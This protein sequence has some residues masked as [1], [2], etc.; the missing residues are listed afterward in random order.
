MY[1]D[2][3]IAAVLPALNEEQALPRVIAGLQ[4]L[5]GPDGQSVIDQIMVCDNGSSDAT[6][7]VA[8]A[9][10]AD[11]VYQAQ[12]GYGI[13]C[14]TAIAELDP[15][16]IILFVDADDSCYVEQAMPLIQAIAEGD[17]LAIGSRTMGTIESG[18]LTYPQRAGN[19]LASL[20]IR[21]LWGKKV[22]DLGPFRAIC[23]S[24]YKQL[25]MQDERFGWTVEMQIK[26]IQH[27]MR[28]SEHPVD[29]KKRLGKSKI[30]GTIS[31]II[32][33]AHGIIGTILKIWLAQRSF[34]RSVQHS[35]I[36]TKKRP[37]QAPPT[38]G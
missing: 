37:I 2:Y 36:K 9:A 7:S 11:V 20:M 12:A 31:G 28:I 19:A 35:H 16:H 25:N 23:Q 34:K 26:A 5:T 32:G 33:A 6:T 18:A 29:S 10:G 4:Q 38:R 17:D 3:R 15:C 27:G 24:A 30:S 21:A 14:L 1:A 13:A 22:S 8:R